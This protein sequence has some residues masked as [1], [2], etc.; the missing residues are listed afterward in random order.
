MIDIA[1]NLNY[2]KKNIPADV[3]L[4]AVSKTKP[5]DQIR[6]AYDQGQRIF[7]ENR[8][9]ELLL[10]KEALPSDIEWHFIGHLQSNKVKSIVPFVS[11][12]HSVDTV[13]LLTTINYEA[14]K[15]NRIIDCL[16]QLHIAKEE[17]KFGFNEVELNDLLA[18]EIIKSIKNVRI[19]GLMG[20]AT[21]T[22]NL[23][24]VKEEFHYLA[25]LFHE[26]KI[27]Y[28]PGK[29]D[30]KEISMGMSGDYKIGIEEGSTMIRLG[31]SIFG[32]R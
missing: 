8:I 20:M 22:E 21:F 31:S 4:V 5:A 26:T 11:M 27:K 9:Q 13:K 15:V 2:F 19:C 6:L 24:L 23:V 32:E 7:G 1:G 25:T 16:L 30:F 3:T 10:K 14:I 18:S 17:T 12:I 29:S 28:F